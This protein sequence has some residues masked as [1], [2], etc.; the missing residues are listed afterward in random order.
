MHVLLYFGSIVNTLVTL[1]NRYF[2]FFL[3]WYNFLFCEIVSSLKCKVLMVIFLSI[4]VSF[5]F[6]FSLTFHPTCSKT[7]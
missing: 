5:L 7:L 3:S 2:F 4:N 6:M 1:L